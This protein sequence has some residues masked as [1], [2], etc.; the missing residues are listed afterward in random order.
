MTNRRHTTTRR[1]VLS[2]EVTVHNAIGP[3]FLAK[4]TQDRLETRLS[5]VQIAK[6]DGVTTNDRKIE[7]IIGNSGRP[8]ETRK[9]TPNDPQEQPVPE[10]RCRS[11]SWS[12]PHSDR[13]L[14]S[15]ENIS[16]GVEIEGFTTLMPQLPAKSF[17][18]LQ[19]RKLELVA[20]PYTTA[21]KVLLKRFSMGEFELIERLTAR[22]E[23]GDKKPNEILQ[24]LRVEEM[25]IVGFSDAV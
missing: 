2:R 7:V 19:P 13:V 4:S 22:L 6:L 10:V 16:E 11:N 3:L 12:L 9:P 20:H 24:K 8:R 25:K 14:V 21:R 17:N 18:E 5:E 1:W 15:A 23:T